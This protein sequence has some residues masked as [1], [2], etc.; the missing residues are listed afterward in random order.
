MG[1]T[2]Y[3][4]FAGC[5]AKL[6][7]GVLD[8]ALCGL[9]Q[10]KFPGLL[11]DF[12]R[13][14]DAGVLRLDDERALVHTVDFFPPIVDDAFTFGRI[15]A[16]NALSDVYAM[17][18][19]PTT[20]VC[21]VGFPVDKLDMALLVKMMEGGLSAL[22]DADCPLVGGHSIDD[23]EPK[24]GYA[25]TGIVHPAKVWLNNTI[26]GG[27]KVILTK[28]I[29]TGLITTAAK[30]GAAS[31]EA[32]TAACDS[33]SFL[34]RT[35]CEVLRRFPVKACTDVTGFGLLGHAC[36]MA[37][38]SPCNIRIDTDAVPLLRS[39]RD[40]ALLKKI[41]GGTKRNKS[42]RLKF[43]TGEKTADEDLV[44]ILFDPQTSGGLLAAVMAGEAVAARDALRQAGV[45]AA[46]IGETVPGTGLI[47]LT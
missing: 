42:F 36:E 38:G 16:A 18:G 30:A 43:I 29:G 20:A 39:A 32:L 19:S 6:G 3:S 27:E 5:G 44:N 17:G 25:V 41:P 26:T 9:S 1:L 46:I 10:R 13:S 15:A 21:L 23:T 8:Q 22:D 2:S 37:S 14:E 4:R 33:M 28:P 35:A 31:A 34:N 12:S 11:A 24:L 7:P 40:Y 47:E 45:P